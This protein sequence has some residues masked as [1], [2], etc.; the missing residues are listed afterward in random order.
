[1]SAL[2]GSGVSGAGP[3]ALQSC[4]MRVMSRGSRASHALRT[5]SSVRTAAIGEAP[6]VE[7]RRGTAACWLRSSERQTRERL[8]PDLRRGRLTAP[9]PPRWQLAG[10][11][12][13]GVVPDR[14]GTARGSPIAVLEQPSSGA[15]RPSAAR[16]RAGRA[17]AA[18]GSK[19]RRPEPAALALGA[20]VELVDLRRRAAGR[21]RGCGRAWHS[22]RACRRSRAPAPGSRG[23]ASAPTSS[24][25][26]GRSSAPASRPGMMPA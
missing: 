22:R 13:G 3:A 15:P 7:S 24:G 8:L 9:P 6:V 18:P 5:S 20:D 10:T 14:G 23:R 26:G 2:R 21:G 19:S 1:M 25:R 12:I 11:T 4:S 17:R 16:G